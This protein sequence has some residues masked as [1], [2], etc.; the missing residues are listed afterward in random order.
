MATQFFA[1]VAALFLT[2]S[3]VLG[4][5][6]SFAYVAS[7]AVGLL[8]VAAALISRAVHSPAARVPALVALAGVALSL[9]GTVT[10]MPFLYVGIGLIVGASAIAL[11][12]RRARTTPL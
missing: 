11:L 4:L 1:V 9:V 3:V 8:F 6:G 2:A 12:T 7:A 5:L 10:T